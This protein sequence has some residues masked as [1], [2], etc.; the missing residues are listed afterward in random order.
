ME[1]I[2]WREATGSARERLEEEQIRR[3]VEVAGWRSPPEASLL[4]RERRRG[5]RDEAEPA[6]AHEGGC[7]KERTCSRRREAGEIAREMLGRERDEG[8]LPDVGRWLKTPAGGDNQMRRRPDRGPQCFQQWRKCSWIMA[9]GCLT[10][11]ATYSKLAP[12]RVLVVIKAA[13]QGKVGETFTSCRYRG[14]KVGLF[15][16]SFL[17]RFLFYKE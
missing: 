6:A 4:V 2:T 15:F 14:K 1:P 17:A 7:R 8:F 13:R 11:E 9:C 3:E 16:S 10:R 12:S 5:D